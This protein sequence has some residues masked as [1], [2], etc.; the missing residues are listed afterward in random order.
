MAL[1]V[2]AMIVKP[3]VCSI[4]DANQ[5]HRQFLIGALSTFT[6]SYGSL[7]IIPFFK[8]PEDHSTDTI[9]WI[10]I[11][12]IYVAGGAATSCIF[13]MNDALASNYARKN[14]ISY[15]RMRIWGNV[16]WAIGAF[17]IMLIGDVSW[18]PSRVPGCIILAI[19]GFTDVAILTL[20]PYP[21][22]FEMFH[23]G[24]TVEQRK[25]SIVG[26]NT[27]ALLAQN[28]PRGSISKDM[29]EKI[30]TGRSKS[31]GMLPRAEV[32]QSRPTGID[33]P[34]SKKK[35]K[36][37]DK[38]Y[39]NFQIQM[40]LLKMI[41]KEHK[42]FI[43]YIIL[44]TIFGIVQSMIWTFQFDYFKA[45]VAKNSE[46]FEFLSTLCMI[47]Q[48]FTG[49]ILVNAV[50]S[51][52]LKMFGANANL[53]LA[54]VTLGMRCFCYSSLLPYLGYWF[55]FVSEGLQGPSLGLYWTLTVDIGSNFAL[56]VTDYIPE[57]KRRG[58]VR[59]RV[60][61]EELNGCL[62]ASMIGFM[63]SSMEGLGNALGAII[64][65]IISTSLGYEAMWNICAAA[66]IS[67]GL[68]NIGWDILSKLVLKRKSKKTLRS[69][70][71]N[72]AIP[73]IIVEE[74]S[75]SKKTKM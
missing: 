29:L 16:G 6:L 26:P 42:S 51:N 66:A 41:A 11:T 30:K 75:T 64:G 67:V 31:V 74:S 8:D 4:T 5:S 12:I 54:L 2:L 38:E 9:T 13:A 65:G 19:F 63:S 35:E 33:S 70:S 32:V 72:L 37:D 71:N 28:R 73:S 17:G 36:D 57:L 68:M 40:L 52:L 14:N 34:K 1:P 55:V 45:R 43:K 18:L 3:V 22:D 24:S 23:D 53:S 7:A 50:A 21:E 60:H 20:W 46:E 48:S 49:E 69:E 15:S 59:D 25:L 61:E 62:R 39:T 47:A 56:M 58:I 27:I 10:I 44:F